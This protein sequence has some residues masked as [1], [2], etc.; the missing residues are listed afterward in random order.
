MIGWAR[1]KIPRYFRPNWRLLGWAREKIPISWLLL[2]LTRGFCQG[3]ARA[4]GKLV[5]EAI[6]RKGRN[7]VLPPWFKKELL[8]DVFITKIRL[9]KFESR[10]R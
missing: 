8:T 9:Y 10:Q 7:L 1:E 2:C 4:P 5:V 6:L 3:I